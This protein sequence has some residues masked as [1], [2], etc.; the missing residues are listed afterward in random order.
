MS[1]VRTS[2]QWNFNE[3]KKKDFNST[4]SNETRSLFVLSLT[5]LLPTLSCILLSIE[6]VMQ[7]MNV[8]VFDAWCTFM[9]GVILRCRFS[10]C[11]PHRGLSDII[12][13][14]GRLICGAPSDA[15]HRRCL[16]IIQIDKCVSFSSCLTFFSGSI[17]LRQMICNNVDEY[18]MGK[19]A[20]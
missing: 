11:H 4:S 14:S 10:F 18:T 19:Q 20:I 12:R 16:I 7:C 15:T 2:K 5:L 17:D 6:L 13:R 3:G 1:E 8:S 9:R